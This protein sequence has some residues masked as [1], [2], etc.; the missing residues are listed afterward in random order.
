MSDAAKNVH[1]AEGLSIL[2]IDD[3]CTTAST[4]AACAALLRRAGAREVKALV[5]ARD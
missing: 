1:P 2:L 5:L 4:L 3:I